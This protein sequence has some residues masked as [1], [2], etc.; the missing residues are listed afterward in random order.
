MTYFRPLSV[1]GKA[2]VWLPSAQYTQPFIPG[3]DRLTDFR[4]AV[5]KKARTALD[6]CGTP[7]GPTAQFTQISIANHKEPAFGKNHLEELLAV[8][9]VLS[10]QTGGSELPRLSDLYGPG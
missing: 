6:H 8:I 1:A 9:L 7:D 2:K 4:K 3:H 5:R 10:L